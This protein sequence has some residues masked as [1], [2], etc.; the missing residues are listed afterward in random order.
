MNRFP[1]I[2]NFDCSVKPFGGARVV[3]LKDWQEAIRFGCS[4]RH[5]RLL[6][7]ALEQALSAEHGPV[8][9]GSG[10]YHHV[11]SLLIARLAQQGPL[12]VVVLDNHPDNM[13]FP[14]GI[15]CGSWVRHVARLPFVSHVHVVGITSSDVSK[16]L[17]QYLWPLWRGK[18]TYWCI[19]VNAPFAKWL[20]FAA[21][22]RVFA[23]PNAL[24]D[25]FSSWIEKAPL[26]VYLSIDKDVLSQEIVH[27]NW[28]QGCFQE[29]HLIRAILLLKNH[30]LGS[31]VTGDISSY[32]YKT[33][34]KRYLSSL[35]GQKVVPPDKLDAWQHRQH[36]VNQLLLGALT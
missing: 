24:L 16:I 32:T 28:D 34:W 11:S 31:D 9:L 2:L 26:P 12:Q 14:F 29:N 3:P 30:I 25:A 17:Q 21:A 36:A 4:M 27:T 18:L 13:R 5:M 1:T 6:A 20:G 7:T 33:W 8:F 23:S 15:H 35:D 19:G 22:V 10:D